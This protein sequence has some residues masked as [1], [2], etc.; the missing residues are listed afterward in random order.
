[1]KVALVSNLF[2]PVGPSAPGGLEVFNYYLM[3][4]LIGKGIDATLY[5]PGDSSSDIPLIPLVD[6]SLQYSESE[7]FLS[8]P[9]NYR[10]MTVKEFAA[11]TRMI[12]K[13]LS[14]ISADRIIH[15]SMVNFLPI[16]L[17][18]KKNMP[19]LV[20]LHMAATNFHF[21][22]LEEIFSE[23]EIKKIHF[24]GVSRNQAKMF[25]HTYKTI[26]NG[27]DSEE[28]RFSKEFRDTFI[29]IGRLVKEK[30]ALD[31]LESCKTANVSL[32][33]G[34]E[35]KSR[36]EVR[37]VETQLKPALTENILEMGLINREDKPNFY[38]AKATIFSSLLNEAAPL[39]IIESM[40]CGTPVIAYETGSAAEVIKDGYNGFL[41]K[42]GDISG[43]VAAIK[44]IESLSP[45]A[46]LTMRENSRKT[47]EE[48]Y[49]LDKMTDKYL[50]TY[51]EILVCNKQ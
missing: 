51:Q 41:I 5:A 37:F 17:A 27:V 10:V 26:A 18:V 39:T 45:S 7:D 20:T 43:I 21:K 22:F 13:D 49:T 32:E 31:A 36:D 6:K 28:L 3:R 24:I 47:I 29:W 15:F 9:W 35:A 14:N 50:E 1:M 42:Q 30:G 46:Y 44:K 33:I 38:S 23:D 48:N 12:D 16:Y 34:G 4:A 19:V 8:V 2:N 40:S 25:P 11:Y